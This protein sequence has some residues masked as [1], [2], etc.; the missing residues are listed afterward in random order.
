[1]VLNFISCFLAEIVDHS[2]N[3]EAYKELIHTALR[4]LIA[5]KCKES[6]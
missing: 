6:P 4:I 3:P 2:N 1:M 5:E